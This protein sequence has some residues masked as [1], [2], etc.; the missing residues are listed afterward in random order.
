[1]HLDRSSALRFVLVVLSLILAGVGQYLLGGGHFRYAI[2]PLLVGIGAMALAVANRPFLAALPGAPTSADET[3]PEEGPPAVGVMERRAGL[4]GFASCAVMLALSLQRFAA[5]PPNTLAWYLFGAAVVVLLLALPALEGRWRRLALGVRDRRRVS[6][7]IRALLPWLGLAAILALALGTRLYHLDELP[8]GL[9]HDEAENLL[10]ASKIHQD[11]GSTPVF[12]TTLPTLYLLPVAGLVGLV[13]ASPA[14]IRL[15]S[16]FFSLAGVV[17]VFLLARLVV[18]PYLALVAAF[19]TAFMRWDIGFSRIGMHGITTPL[20]TA[21]TAYLTLRALRGGRV[22][23][24]GYAGAALGLGMW[25]Y[26][27]FRLFPLVVGI[28]LLH[29]LLTRRPRLRPFVG[30]VVAMALVALV[31]AAPVVHSA[32]DE[33]D[34]FFA[35]T[36]STSVFSVAPFGEAIGD[37]VE[38]LGKHAL[39]FSHKGD[40]NP[41]HNLPNEPL[42]DFLSGLLFMLGL[43]VALARWREVGLIVLPFWVLVMIIPGVLTLPWEAPQF[44]RTIG[45]GPAVAVAIS[46]VFGVVWWAGR[47]SPWAAVRFATPAVLVAALGIIAFSNVDT[48]FGQQ[49]RH[50]EVYASFSTAET[51]IARDMVRR[52]VDG[53]GLL[54]SRQ[55]LHN[56]TILLIAGD[57]DYQVIRVPTGVPLAPDQG[58]KGVS[59]YI[60]PR[61]AG[62]Y[63]LLKAYYP[64]GSFEE[65]R[66]PGGGEVLYHSA[67]ISRDQL[68]GPMGLAAR[69]VLA[70]GSVREG[71]QISTESA[72]P[73]EFESDQV[74]FDMEWQGALHITE[75]GEYLL[76]VA[77][78]GATGVEVTLDGR[79][80][81]GG[82]RAQVRIVPGVGLHSLR[83][84]G[85]VT[86]RAGYLRFSLQRPGEQLGPVTLERLYHGAVRPVG[87]AGRFYAGE[88]EGEVPGAMRATPAMDVF[89]YDPVIF[90]PYLA[91][92]EG[93]LDVSAAGLHGFSVSG[94]GPVSLFLDGRPVAQGGGDGSGIQKLTLS[95]GVHSVRV[96]YL[97]RSAPS[98]LKVLWEPPGGPLSSVPIERLSPSGEHMFR[99]LE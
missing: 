82:E 7:E 13:D 4:A 46:L 30:R 40:A 23:D 6:F 16:V 51:L 73:L 58:S 38:G 36:R 94:A 88:V 62:V 55:F 28:I 56:P 65:V 78:E 53:Y 72:W 99:V 12:A 66:P 1:M 52:R 33:P 45:A 96:E 2:T 98:E 63:R 75:P 25:F 8:A 18:G 42:L 95:A 47:S 32:I 50:P 11:P 54:I 17:A 77:L 93:T 79:P 34:E 37:V 49:A 26:S 19:V 57:G 69:Y 76:A 3:L 22:S 9:W 64:E 14:A 31:V 24:F 90:E 59:V 43:G 91:V 70:D 74:P 39:M 61:E 44:L 35:R 71:V 85:R 10:E 92:W 5:G 67:L 29:H 81:L 41:R 97:S 20:F 27:A 89:Y 21:L 48:Y 80:V 15:V 60:E 84:V 86:D 83:V 87:L 68:E